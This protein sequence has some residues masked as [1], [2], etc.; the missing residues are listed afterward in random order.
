MFVAAGAWKAV[1]PVMQCK[2]RTLKCSAPARAMASKN[3]AAK[4]LK[5]TVLSTIVH[6]PW[7]FCVSSTLRVP[8]PRQ[9]IGICASRAVTS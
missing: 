4:L 1:N 8:D 7:R 5:S 9:R 6:Y 2:R 3:N